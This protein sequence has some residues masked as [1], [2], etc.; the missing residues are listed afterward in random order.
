MSTAGDH[1]QADRVVRCLNCDRMM[2]AAAYLHPSHVCNPDS[3]FVGDELGGQPRPSAV[4]IAAADAKY[5]RRHRTGHRLVDIDQRGR[6][7]DRAQRMQETAWDYYSAT[8]DGV[9]N[10]KRELLAAKVRRARAKIIYRDAVA[11]TAK[12]AAD[13]ERV[14]S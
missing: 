11:A 5:A 4:R 13:Y 1:R 2:S 14:T 10:A 9:G 12:S 7:L 8:I 6:R 3:R